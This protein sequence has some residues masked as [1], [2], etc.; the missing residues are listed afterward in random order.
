M[1]SIEEILEE[2]YEQRRFAETGLYERTSLVGGVP[3]T[4]YSPDG[5]HWFSEQGAT[6][7]DGKRRVRTRRSKFAKLLTGDDNLRRL[8]RAGCATKK[9]SSFARLSFS[10]P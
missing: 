8:S 3:V 1:P 9:T 2:T 6:S 7:N 5:V 10:A 4:L